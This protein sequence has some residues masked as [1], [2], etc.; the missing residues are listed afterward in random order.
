M[1]MDTEPR[2]HF[3]ELPELTAREEADLWDTLEGL[4]CHLLAMLFESPAAVKL[5]IQGL[6][7]YHGRSARR[8]FGE[9]AVPPRRQIAR[10]QQ[11]L[12]SG[13]AVEL[14]HGCIRRI[15]SLHLP[16]TLLRR[17]IRRLHDGEIN[18]FWKRLN[19]ARQRMALSH[20]RLAVWVAT[21]HL[22]S[23]VPS[24]DLVQEGFIG[25]MKA[26]EKFC[27]HRG[28]RFSTYAVWWIRRSIVRAIQDK[29]R[30]VRL[31]IGRQHDLWRL[32]GAGERLSQKLGRSPTLEEMARE[33][34][35]PVDEAESLWLK[36]RRP[37]SIFI[38][39]GENS[40]L[41][42]RLAV[43]DPSR[44]EDPMSARLHR[45]VEELPERERKIVSLRFGL[46]DGRECALRELSVH[47]GISAERVRQIQARAIRRLQ[48]C[49]SEAPE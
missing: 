10:L 4:Y 21:Q 18:R 20:A 11:I 42:D 48:E 44:E 36:A 9:E 5:I 34:R 16:P 45:A 40:R 27:R 17:V 15:G 3:P 41:S 30:T 26:V 2:S 32:N 6:A 33:A 35:L 25:L 12:R 31:P 47:F 8:T 28:F 38:S 23:G 43:E 19:E 24:D 39:V 1:R 46:Q 7:E 14:R 49:L 37:A 29:S 22:E 13:R